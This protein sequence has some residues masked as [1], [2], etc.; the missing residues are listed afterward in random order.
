MVGEVQMGDMGLE[1]GCF[2]VERPREMDRIGVWGFGNVSR[3]VVVFLVDEGLGKE[4]VFY[5]RPRPDYPNR[6]GAWIEDLKANA[7]R[8]PRLIGTNK[9][10]DMAGL[11]VIFVGAGVPRREGQSRRDLLQVNT[12]IIAQTALEIRKLYG[13]CDPERLPVL[14]FMG[15]P[16]TTMTWVGYKVS[17]FPR[18]KVMGQAGNLDARRICYAVAKELGISGNEM[19]GI[20]FGDHGD[21]M[22]VSPRFFSVGGIPLDLLLEAE[23]VDPSRI[24]AILE[25]AKKGGTHFVEATGHS[26]SVGPAKAVGQMLRAIISGEPEV[27]PVVAI[28]E[29]EYGLIEPQDNIDSMGFGVPAKIGPQGVEEI[30]ELGIQDIREALIASA[31]QIKEDTRVA[32]KILMEKFGIQ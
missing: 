11:D 17:G 10:E 14:V 31:A 18:Q 21:S 4:I 7:T 30:Y 2:L 26:A 29:K 6:A 19:K 16:V 25:Q 32:A 20:V 28:L 23:G 1:R 9:V 27:Q 12:E 24:G 13:G 15:N 8:R 5:G 22:V 3:D